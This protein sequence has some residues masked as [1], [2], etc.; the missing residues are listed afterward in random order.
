MGNFFTDTAAQI[1]EGFDPGGWGALIPG[2]VPAYINQAANTAPKVLQAAQGRNAGGNRPARRQG[3]GDQR[4]FQERLQAALKFANLGPEGSAEVMNSFLTLKALGPNNRK[5]KKSAYRQA[6]QL[7]LDQLSGGGKNDLSKSLAAQALAQQFLQPLVGN[8]MNTANAQAGLQENLAGTLPPQFQ[9]YAQNAAAN[10]RTQA[11]DMAATYA[12][13][14]QMVPYM[15]SLQQQ[16]AQD[17][18]LAQQAY[19]AQLQGQGGST[20]G[21]QSLEEAL[22]AAG[23]GKKK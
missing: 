10:Q 3:R 5:G 14:L 16:Q 2:N 4:N 17:A 9:M 7:L 6:S 23:V 19:Q 18:Q 12:N 15:N 8:M 13:Q 20:G 22:A 1:G 21:S 11:A